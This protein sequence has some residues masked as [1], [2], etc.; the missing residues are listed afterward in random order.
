MD[1]TEK[2]R[3]P[4]LLV[5][6]NGPQYETQLGGDVKKEKSPRTRVGTE[7]EGVTDPEPHLSVVEDVTFVV[8][9]T[10]KIGI[11]KHGCHGSLTG[12]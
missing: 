11:E 7:S 3:G 2:E 8:T 1:P 5:I 6:S 10:P 12:V 4:P 9:V